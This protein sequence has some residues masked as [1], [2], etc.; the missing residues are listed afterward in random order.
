MN[1]TDEEKVKRWQ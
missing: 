1:N